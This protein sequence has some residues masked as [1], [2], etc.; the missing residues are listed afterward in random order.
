MFKTSLK[1]NRAAFKSIPDRLNE[2]TDMSQTSAP[3]D[4]DLA[5]QLMRTQHVNRDNDLFD[6]PVIS[7]LHQVTEKVWSINRVP[8]N[9]LETVPENWQSR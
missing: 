6:M 1:R 2:S 9:L 3:H 5:F 8:K 4:P 7:P